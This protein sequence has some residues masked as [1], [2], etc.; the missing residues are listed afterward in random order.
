MKI[1]NRIHRLKIC[2]NVTESVKRFVYLYIVLGEKIHI[3]DTG[4]A[5]SETYV[6]EYLSELGRDMKEVASVLLTHSHPD[7][8]GSAQAIKELSNCTVY[9]CEKEKDWIENIDI[10]FK[11]RPIPNFYHLVNVSPCIDKIIR[12]GDVLRLEKDI[13]VEVLE[14]N[15]HSHGSLSFYWI[16]ESIL[17]TGDSIPV[18]GEIPIYISANDSIASL[19]KIRSLP[20]VRYYLSAWDEIFDGEGGL[21]NI[22]K[23]L[24]YLLL[25]DNTVK[26]ILSQN[27]DMSEPEIFTKVCQSLNITHLIDNPLFKQSVYANIRETGGAR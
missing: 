4:V 6:S 22:E 9:A 12:N 14:T 3:I 24:E 20:N 27:S 21:K 19:K 7:H 13:T 26:E 8:I 5:G 1:G 10:Q 15:G 18:V 25:I 23:S 16:E 2:F 17:F 11:H